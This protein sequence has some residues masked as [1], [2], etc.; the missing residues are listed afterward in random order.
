MTLHV[1]VWLKYR[2]IKS[3]CFFPGMGIKGQKEDPSFSKLTGKKRNFSV[4][5]LV[6]PLTASELCDSPLHYGEIEGTKRVSEE[7][8]E[9]CK[10]V[11]GLSGL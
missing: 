1:M 8:T 3:C 6:P 9:K 4:H 10:E 5:I 2:L 11:K 7:Q